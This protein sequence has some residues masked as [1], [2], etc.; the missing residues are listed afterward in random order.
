MNPNQGQ[1]SEKN[2]SEV[3]PPVCCCCP[4]AEKLLG[5]PPN[6][7]PCWARPPNDGVF[8]VASAPKDGALVG[9][10]KLKRGGNIRWQV[11][12][13]ES[14]WLWDAG[15]LDAISRSGIDLRIKKNKAKQKNSYS[16]QDA[17]CSLLSC[18]WGNT[19]TKQRKSGGVCVSVN[20]STWGL[21]DEGL[22][23]NPFHRDHAC[24]VQRERKRE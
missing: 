3:S 24:L 19:L 16:D 9:E 22:R 8:W 18:L 6:P 21:S 14:D 20:Q 10:A 11:G 1:R 2:I 7:G 15:G 5:W 12:L 23:G 4:K 13:G 17:A